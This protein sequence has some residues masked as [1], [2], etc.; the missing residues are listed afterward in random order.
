MKSNTTTIFI[1]MKT[2]PLFPIWNMILTVCKFLGM[3][4]AV[5]GIAHVQLVVT[6]QAVGVNNAV[7][8]DF[9]LND[10]E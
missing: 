4:D 1:T 7:R 10:R 9:L 5:I 3:V 2:I 6:A 8:H